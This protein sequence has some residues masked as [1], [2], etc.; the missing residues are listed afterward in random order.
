MTGL[1]QKLTDR[2]YRPLKAAWD[3]APKYPYT[4]FNRDVFLMISSIINTLTDLCC[5][6]VPTLIVMKLMLPLRKKLAIVLVLI[7][8]VLVNVTSALRIYFAYVESENGNDVWYHYA[9]TICST[10]EV[11]LGVVRF[12]RRHKCVCVCVSTDRR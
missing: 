2:A 7:T 11:G 4:C 5:T 8:G 1:L 9:P 3:P 12:P 6:I 10:F